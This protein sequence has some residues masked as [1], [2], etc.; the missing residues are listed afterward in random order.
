VTTRAAPAKAPYSGKGKGR[1][2]RGS[3]GGSGARPSAPTKGDASGGAVAEKEGAISDGRKKARTEPVVEQAEPVCA[4]CPRVNRNGGTLLSPMLGPFTFRKGKTFFI[5]HICAM[6][7][8]EVYHDPETDDLRNAVAAYHRSRGLMCSVCITNGATVGCYVPECARAYHYCCLYGLP[9]PSSSHPEENGPC[10][11]H[12]D[13]YAAFCPEHS[14]R[15][16]D[17]AYVRRMMDDAAL[18]TFLSNRAA[19]VQAALEHEP[20]QGMDCPNYQVT[21]LRRNE[22]ETIFCRVWGVSSVDFDTS[23][24]T[25]AGS[26]YRRVVRSGERV[27]LR[28]HP[29]QVPRCALSV[30]LRVSAASI[31]RGTAARNETPLATMRSAVATDDGAVDAGAATGAVAAAD[32]W[33]AGVGTRAADAVLPARRPPIFLLRNLKRVPGAGRGAFRRS[34]PAVPGSFLRTTVVESVRARPLSLPAGMGS[35][36]PRG[37]VGRGGLNAPGGGRPGSAAGGSGPAATHSSGAGTAGNR[38]AS[39][40][41]NF[42]GWPPPRPPPSPTSGEKEGRK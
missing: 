28:E 26:H 16:N 22:T 19:A 6:W 38:G 3:A 35:V 33:A 40:S 37:P 12:E 15:A 36:L 27:E 13:F 20:M 21:G 14:A 17:E 24:I 7:A 30:A 41:R 10:V 5:H 25:I 23:W 29:R 8:P 1:A 18:S 31:V 32:Q 39:G 9:P 11:R 2:G 4:F 42:S 34:L